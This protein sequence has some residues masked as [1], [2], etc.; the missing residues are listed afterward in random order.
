MSWEKFETTA[1]GKWVLAGEHAVLRGATAIALPLTDRVLKLRFIPDCSGELRVEPRDATQIIADLLQSLEDQWQNSDRSF[2]R[3]SGTL[4]IESTIPI[5]AGMGSSA[6]LCVALTRW[7]KEPLSIPEDQIFEFARRLEHRFHGRSS[8][9]DVAVI[10]AGQPIS[11]S[12]SN[13]DVK[14]RTLGIRKLPN[15]SFHDTGMRA[16]TSECILR[17]EQLREDTP[18]LAMSLDENMGS[19]SR[20]AM[21]GLMLFDG[22]NSEAGIT[23]IAQAMR[24][25]QECYYSWRLVPAEAKHLEEDL[26]KQGALAVK[27]TGAGGGG[28][29]VA[30]WNSFRKPQTA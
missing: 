12:I 11:F 17:V 5:G 20:D 2:P 13:D 7:M 14:I 21:E 27:L 8:G 30:M 26:L 3:P 4:A 24:K 15:F 18:V 29:L 6:A 10:L 22:G 25:A 1:S 19:A 23:L 9:M 28:F 16:R